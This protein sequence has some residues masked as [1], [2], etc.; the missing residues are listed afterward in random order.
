MSMERQ[1]RKRSDACVPEGEFRRTVD[2]IRLRHDCS[3][4]PVGVFYAFDYRTRMGPYSY[5]DRR[6]PPAGV[7]NVGGTLYNAGFKRTRIILQQWSPKVRPSRCRIDGRPLEMMLISAMQIHSEPAYRLVEDACRLGEDRPFIVVGGPKASYEPWDFFDPNGGASA[8]VATTGE[9]YCFMQLLERMLEHK[10]STEHLRD[11]F[12]RLRLEGLLDDI[13]GLVYRGEGTIDG[14]PHLIATEVPRVVKDLDEF[15]HPGVGLRIMEPP[16]RRHEL[17]KYTLPREKVH[18]YVRIVPMLTTQGCRFG[19][20]Y[21]PIPAFNHRQFR[22]KSPERIRQELS[23]LAEDFGISTFFGADDNFFNRRKVAED[24]MQEMARGR[25]NGRK[26]RDSIFFLTEA[27][28]ADVYRH[29]DLLD[30]AREA[31]FRGLYFGIE[32]MT[33]GLVEKGQSVQKVEE[34]FPLLRAKGIFPMPM[35]M[36]H[37]EQR[38]YSGNRLAGIMDQVRF[39]AKHGAASVQVTSLMPMV[40]SKLYEVLFDQGMVV[41]QVG[42]KKVADYLYDGNH[43]IASKHRFPFFRQM[44]IVRAYSGFY[45]PINF[46]KKLPRLRD[47][48]CRLEALFQITGMITVAKSLYR[49][50]GWFNQLWWGPIK[51]YQQAPKPPWRILPARSGQMPFLPQLQRRA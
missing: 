39:M 36:Y 42:T 38:L 30:L 4:M 37:D 44:D 51:T 7:M 41:S 24:I 8:D 28:L 5:V 3:E 19:C 16:H 27:T 21:C 23:D 18:K 9:I 26:F 47:E 6:L 48:S 43:V 32:D 12:H 13:P 46:L 11:A 50:L 25:V 34:L 1:I 40:G 2:R 14:H 15:P 33:A 35:L 31:G 45:N 49:S 29:Q 22:T 10:A 20:P 17:S